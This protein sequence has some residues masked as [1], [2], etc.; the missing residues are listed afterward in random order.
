MNGWGEAATC[1]DGEVTLVGSAYKKEGRVE[2][3]FNNTWY[4]VCGDDWTESEASVVCSQQGYSPDCESL[5]SC[6]T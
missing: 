1:V 4:A 3:C 5:S 6:H 2:I